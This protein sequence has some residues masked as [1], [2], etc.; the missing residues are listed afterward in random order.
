MI[1]ECEKVKSTILDDVI[2]H[3]AEWQENANALEPSKLKLKETAWAEYDPCFTHVG[4]KTHLTALELRP[5]KSNISR[6]MCPDFNNIPVHPAFNV[7][8]AEMLSDLTLLTIVRDLFYAN[9]IDRISSTTGSSLVKSHPHYAYH[10]LRRDWTL[11]CPAAVFSK[12]VQLLTLMIHNI[13]R[14]KGDQKLDSSIV[15]T[16]DNRRECFERFIL[17]PGDLMLKQKKKGKG[18]VISIGNIRIQASSSASAAQR[19][20]DEFGVNF[21]RFPSDESYFDIAMEESTDEAD[22]NG[23]EETSGGEDSSHMPLPPLLNTIMD[24]Y[25]SFSTTGSSEDIFIKQ[26]LFWIIG[27]LESTLSSKCGE[28]ICSKLKEE[29]H[30]KR[31]LEMKEKREKARERAMQAMKK[32]ATAFVEHMEKEVRILADICE[33]SSL[34]VFFYICWCRVSLRCLMTSL[35]TVLPR[36]LHQATTSRLFRNV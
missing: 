17:S 26:S 36:Q 30:E 1:P 5:K 24:I 14:P 6:P 28:I 25:D 33:H 7:V 15:P 10:M 29:L 13:A 11:R 23:S 31:R 2:G 32:N 12:A 20:M 8:R 21:E 4:E 19:I 22:Q 16:L 18:R 27:T 9:M 35:M 34:I 3:V